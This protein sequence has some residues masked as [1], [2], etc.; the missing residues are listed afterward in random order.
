MT[1]FWSFLYYTNMK[2]VRPALFTLT[3]CVLVTPNRVLWQTV[4]TQMKCRKMRHFIGDCT[5]CYIKLKSIFKGWITI[6]LIWK[7]WKSGIM[8]LY[9]KQSNNNNNSWATKG[10]TYKLCVGKL[11]KI[12]MYIEIEN[13]WNKTHGNSRIICTVI[14]TL[15]SAE[16]IDIKFKI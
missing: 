10:L 15:S 11:W 9:L 5:I 7:F 6:I 3:L 2:P 8:Y 1:K 13:W 12:Y 4:K 16:T 14:Y